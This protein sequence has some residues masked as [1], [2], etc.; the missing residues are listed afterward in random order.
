MSCVYKY[1]ANVLHNSTTKVKNMKNR[2]E[3]DA[4][5]REFGHTLGMEEVDVTRAKRTAKNVVA[6]ALL[7]VALTVFGQIMMP[8][9]PSGMYYSGASIKDF[10]ILFGG[11][12]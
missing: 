8:G 6:M 10:Q 1:R 4:K 7:T 2:K 9:G 5:L 11:L 12:V 3:L